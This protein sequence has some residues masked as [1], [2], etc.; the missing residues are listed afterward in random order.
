[1][2][3]V[4]VAGLIGGNYHFVSDI[5]GGLYLGVGTGIGMRALMLSPLDRLR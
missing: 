2:V 5:V 1:M 4:V 3:A